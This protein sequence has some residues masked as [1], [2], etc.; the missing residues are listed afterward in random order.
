MMISF[1]IIHKSS[2]I[3]NIKHLLPKAIADILKII[4][5]VAHDLNIKYN[6]NLEIDFI[7][8]GPRNILLDLTKSKDIDLVI[9]D[10]KK[11]IEKIQLQKQAGD[12]S[13]ILPIGVY[14]AKQ[15]TK[16]LSSIGKVTDVAF[17]KNFGTASF[18]FNSIEIEIVGARKESYNKNSRKPIVEDGDRTD[19]QERRDFTMNA[20][21]IRLNPS[22]FGQVIDPF[23]GVKDIKDK[24]IRTPTDPNITFSDDP[25]RMM[26]AIRFATVLGFKISKPT[27]DSILKNRDRIKI[28]SNERIIEEMSK[29]FKTKNAWKGIQLMADSGLLKLILPE[30]TEL[31]GRSCRVGKNGKWI[32]HKDNLYH[33]IQVIKNIGNMLDEFTHPTL[34]YWTALLHDVG[35]TKTKR[36]DK[37]SGTNGNWTFHSHQIVSSKMVEP[38]FRRLKLPLGFELKY[39]RFMVLNHE[40]IKLSEIISTDAPIRRILADVQET[41]CKNDKDDLI[42]LNDEDDLI[43]LND[44]FNFGICDT[45]SSHASVKEKRRIT[46]TTLK[47]RAKKIREKDNLKNFQPP[48]KGVEIMSLF[49]LK[50]CKTVGLLKDELKNAIIE[51]RLKNDYESTLTYLINYANTK[52]NLTNNNLK[53]MSKEVVSKKN[54]LSEQYM[55]G[56]QFELDIVEDKYNPTQVVAWAEGKTLCKFNKR[57][58]TPGVSSTVLA[59]VIEIRERYLLVNA[60]KTIRTSTKNAVAR[61]SKKFSVKK[62]K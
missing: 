51:G 15:V 60:L 12:I 29:M 62:L 14:F 5:N 34:M 54:P 19:D 13:K 50:P 57:R 53:I 59:E 17:Y 44:L 56:I 55:V 11:Q 26:R 28:I 38:I 7:G 24:I 30:V 37:N 3:M 52:F 36:F 18:L 42:L 31:K 8:G 49:S 58:I 22:V 27:W 16:V 10:S 32:Y 9:I 20:I 1:F 2:L 47:K 41:L 35:K 39:V 43:L 46:Y 40:K 61:L 33:V 23:N 4:G 45:S 6:A 48:I 21:A 25:L